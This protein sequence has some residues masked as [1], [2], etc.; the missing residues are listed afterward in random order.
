MTIEA[1]PA[2]RIDDS[3]EICEMLEKTVQ[4]V[5]P[6]AE[7]IV[8]FEPAKIESPDLYASARNLAAMHGLD[9]HALALTMREDGLH[10]HAHI[11]LP[12]EMSIAKAH[13][14]VSAYEHDL[15][16]RLWAKH[17]V[18][19]IEPLESVDRSAPLHSPPSREQV[20]Q[21]LEKIRPHHKDVGELFDTEI[22]TMGANVDLS[23]RCKTNGSRTVAETHCM[24][25]RMEAEIRNLLPGIGRISIHFEPESNFNT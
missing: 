19:H 6:G 4:N 24:A 14:I 25:S 22:W 10:I 17:V 5:L 8:H 15:C 11:E 3:H 12:S 23:F 7:T 16:K 13:K 21:T 2:M 20:L 18:S 1:P 9:I